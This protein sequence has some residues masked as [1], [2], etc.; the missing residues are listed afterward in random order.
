[1]SI[2]REYYHGWTDIHIKEVDESCADEPDVFCADCKY[3]RVY[4]G[5]IDENHYDE[6]LPISYFNTNI[7]LN[8]L[9]KEVIQ[10]IIQKHTVYKDGKYV[11]RKFK[12]KIIRMD[13]KLGD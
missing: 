8:A 10:G 12:D 9:C 7:I 11:G 3:W 1:V 13:E 5:V 6:T 2:D 4:W